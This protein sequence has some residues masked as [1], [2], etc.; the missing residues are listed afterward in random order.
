MWGENVPEQSIHAYTDGSRAK[1]NID[2]N[3]S[4]DNTTA[5]WACLI[6]DDNF[7]QVWERLHETNSRLDREELLKKMRIPTWSAYLENAE[8][9]YSTEL[10][11]ITQLAM[12]TPS[13]WKLT[14]HTDSKSSIDSINTFD[15]H[16][17]IRRKMKQS[18]WKLLQLFHE[19][20]QVRKSPITLQWV[21]AHQK[22]MEIEYVD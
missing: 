6:H 4:T 9:S 17:T 5:S 10:E 19:V 21:A 13:T 20:K 22:K 18:N 14:I 7:Q 1:N 15:P 3:H 8:S 2:E 16:Q 11:A 12:V